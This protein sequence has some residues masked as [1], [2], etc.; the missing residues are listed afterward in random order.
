M[1]D[2]GRAARRTPRNRWKCQAAVVRGGPQLPM[3]FTAMRRTFIL[4]V[5][6]VIIFFFF[7][8][9]F[10]IWT[11]QFN[12]G[13]ALYEWAASDMKLNS[14]VAFLQYGL[15]LFLSAITLWLPREY[16]TP[17]IRQRLSLFILAAS[18]APYVM[19]GHGLIVQPGLFYLWFV[20]RTLYMRI[21]VADFLIF[22]LI[23]VMIPTI[24][25]TALFWWLVGSEARGEGTF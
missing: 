4:L 15:G 19:I 25:L 5:V 20:L 21:S 17:L 8:V 11:A 24:L 12:K 1:H 10:E 7:A 14:P 6:W 9:I 13:R 16:F 3:W 23:P 2:P 18:L 22:F